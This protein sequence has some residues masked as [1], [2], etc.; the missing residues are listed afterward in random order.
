MILRSERPDVERRRSEVL[1]LQGEQN[2][3]L[4]ELEEGLLNQLSATQVH[5]LPEQQTLV[6]FFQ[7]RGGSVAGDPPCACACACLL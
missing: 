3:K 5:S 2:V 1:R 6:S 7:R 4:R